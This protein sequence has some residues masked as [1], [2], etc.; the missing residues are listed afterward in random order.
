M[1]TLFV[2]LVGILFS[3]GSYA[4]LNMPMSKD[5]LR[6]RVNFVI[7]GDSL[8][9]T[10]MKYSLKN[11]EYNYTYY[12]FKYKKTR[13]E[14]REMWG[15]LL[16]MALCEEVKR[17]FDLSPRLLLLGGAK[18]YNLGNE[19]DVG[20]Q[21]KIEFFF[22]EHLELLEMHFMGVHLPNVFEVI[23]DEQLKT[24]CKEIV[25]RQMVFKEVFRILTPAEREGRSVEKGYR[26]EV[27]INGG[28]KWGET[29]KTKEPERWEEICNRFDAIM[30]QK[31]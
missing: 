16:D 15:W 23:S 7:H 27:Y 10:K 20:D 3:M 29:R 30:K 5:T 25:K 22:N 8:Q 13:K 19:E 6:D 21:L 31:E 18:A 17:L 12:N 11:F 14:V 4:Q 24:I 2:L 28:L 26:T 1:R 9:M